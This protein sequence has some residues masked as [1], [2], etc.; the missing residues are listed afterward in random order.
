MW[1]ESP[2]PESEPV[3]GKKGKNGLFVSSWSTQKT[4]RLGAQFFLYLEFAGVTCGTFSQNSVYVTDSALLNV[5]LQSCAEL[6]IEERMKIQQFWTYYEGKI[7]CAMDLPPFCIQVSLIASPMALTGSFANRYRSL[8][9]ARI[10][11]GADIR[12]AFSLMR[13]SPR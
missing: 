7:A 6:F 2:I 9:D 3:C 13:T 8:G 11:L 12:V 10:H 5:F 1:V 4:V